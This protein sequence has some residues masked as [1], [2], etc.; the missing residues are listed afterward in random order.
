MARL[1][2]LAAAA[3]VQNIRTPALFVISDADTVVR[4]DLTRKVAERW[5]APRELI[6]VEQHRRSRQSRH[7]RRRHVAIDD[8]R[9]GEA[10]HRMGYRRDAMKARCQPGQP[11]LDALLPERPDALAAGLVGRDADVAQLRVG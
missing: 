4:P 6:A 5:G 10:H 7:C 8:R 2:E 9:A 3:R 1:V 11:T